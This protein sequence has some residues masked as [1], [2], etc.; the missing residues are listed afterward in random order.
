MKRLKDLE[1]ENRRLKQMYADL[2]LG[3]QIPKDIVEKSSDDQRATRASRPCEAGPPL[4][5]GKLVACWV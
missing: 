2:S 5:R 1:A 3:H 4:A